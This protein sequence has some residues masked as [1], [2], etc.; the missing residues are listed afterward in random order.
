M[1]KERPNLGHA[2]CVN[3]GHEF[4]MVVHH[5]A[6]QSVLH[7]VAGH[8]QQGLHLAEAVRLVVAFIQ[9]VP[10]LACTT[11]HSPEQIAEVYMWVCLSE[12]LYRKRLPTT[13]EILNSRLV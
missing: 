3:K 8:H 13:K 10:T 6:A 2:D 11:A 5:Q 9:V 7:H 1:H 4:L 12:C